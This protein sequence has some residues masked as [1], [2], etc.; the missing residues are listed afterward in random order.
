[1]NVIYLHVGFYYFV[2]SEYPMGGTFLPP[3]KSVKYHA[4]EY[5]GRAR[6]PKT[7]QNYSTIGIHHYGW[8]LKDHSEF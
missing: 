2:D 8:S 5:R 3:Y 4:Q 6:R 1:M 7:N